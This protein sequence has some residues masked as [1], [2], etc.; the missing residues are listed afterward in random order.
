MNQTNGYNI[1][2]IISLA[3]VKGVLKTDVEYDLTWETGE[4][5]Y[6]EFINSKFNVDTKGE[7]ECIIDFL[8]EIIKLTK[9]KNI[10]K[11]KD[12][13]KFRLFDYKNELTVGYQLGS[14]VTLINMEQNP[15]G[16]V[17]Q[18]FEDTN[19]RTDMFGMSSTEEVRPST[20]EDIK[21]HR[22]ELLS[23]IK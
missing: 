17:I 3:Q 14:I 1:Y 23:E 9:I 6:G 20:L 22:P 21:N 15:V 12:H 13:N 8:N 4:A 19:F 16:V 5:M 11:V 7:Y 10:I 18:T 2:L